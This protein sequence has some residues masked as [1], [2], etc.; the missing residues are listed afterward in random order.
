MQN[1]NGF[2]DLQAKSLKSY[3]LAFLWCS[4]AQLKETLQCYV[5]KDV[6]LSK[7]SIRE[8][9]LNDFHHPMLHSYGQIIGLVTFRLELVTISPQLEKYGDSEKPN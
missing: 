1:L 7:F 2:R 9:D 3:F 8:S 4:E 5:S 6:K